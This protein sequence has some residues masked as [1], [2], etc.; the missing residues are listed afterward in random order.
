MWRASIDLP[1]DFETDLLHVSTFLLR[2]R[3]PRKDIVGLLLVI[4]NDEL[5]KNMFLVCDPA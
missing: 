2:V 3:N 4:G 5:A 1:D